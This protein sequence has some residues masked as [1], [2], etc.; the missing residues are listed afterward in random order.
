MVLVLVVMLVVP[1]RI[2]LGQD[3]GSPEAGQHERCG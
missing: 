3:R 1:V 2:A